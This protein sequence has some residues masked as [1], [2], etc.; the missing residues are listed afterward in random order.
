MFREINEEF[1]EEF[2]EMMKKFRIRPQELSKGKRVG[3]IVYGW[4]MVIGPDGKPIVRQFG[5]VSPRAFEGEREPLVDV[6]ET[7]EEVVVVAEIPGADKSE[8]K[9]NATSNQ[10]EIKVPNKYYKLVDLPTEVVPDKAKASYR[11]G[12]LEVHLQKKEK[13]EEPKGVSV[14]IE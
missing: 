4:S 6:N 5:N 3:P 12:V 14:P 1:E 8:I 9:L 13:K 7:P 11:N 10:L 2:E